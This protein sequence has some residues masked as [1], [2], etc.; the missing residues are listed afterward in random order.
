M[1]N[2]WPRLEQL[3][4]LLMA[5]WTELSLDI[6]MFWAGMIFER[7]EVVIGR[8]ALMGDREAFEGVGSNKASGPLGLGIDDH[9][10]L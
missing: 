7:G 9:S 4:A 2:W 6:F 10:N 5:I 8:L 3:S 1:R